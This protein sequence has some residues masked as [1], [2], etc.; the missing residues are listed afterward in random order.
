MPGSFDS[1]FSLIDSIRLWNSASLQCFG[2]IFCASPEGFD[3]NAKRSVVCSAG[4]LDSL[5]NPAEA[6]NGQRS[7]GHL[8]HWGK[9][10]TRRTAKR[11]QHSL[12][13]SL[14]LLALLELLPLL[15]LPA[16]WACYGMHSCPACD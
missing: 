12:D 6:Q 2:G 11:P 8:A 14:L 9:P 3:W 15:L 10:P 16:T 13:D 1:V 7:T 5:I 4:I